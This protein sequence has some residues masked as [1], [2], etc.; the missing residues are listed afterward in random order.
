MKLFNPLRNRAEDLLQKAYDVGE[1]LKHS[2]DGRAQ[3]EHNNIT[4][5]TLHFISTLLLQIRDLL[6]LICGMLIANALFL[7]RKAFLITK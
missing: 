1:V 7:F 4:A 5:E 6:F 3:S 2:V